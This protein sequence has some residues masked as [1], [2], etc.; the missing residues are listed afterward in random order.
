MADKKISELTAL[1][2]GSL[3]IGDMVPIVDESDDETKR[4][5]MGDI[6]EFLVNQGGLAMYATST[7]PRAIGT[8]SK[9]FVLDAPSSIL[10]ALPYVQ[11]ADR[12]DENVWMEGKVTSYIGTALTVNV[13]RVSGTGAYSNWIIG[14]AGRPAE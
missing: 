4:T 6:A 11:V 5:T 14:V 13:S 3:A 9:S 8:G 2:S 1:P 7:T 12:D 10:F